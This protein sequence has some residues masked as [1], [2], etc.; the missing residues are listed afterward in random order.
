MNI[1][2]GI[3]IGW[4]AD[5]WSAMIV[6][7]VLWGFGFCVWQRLAAA[8]G[9][10]QAPSY[11]AGARASA[12]KG[13]VTER[14]DHLLRPSLFFCRCHRCDFWGRNQYA[15]LGTVSVI[16]TRV[17]GHFACGVPVFEVTMVQPDVV[18]Q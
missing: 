9:I 3:V 16:G 6:A 5:T 13:H 7:A 8:L 11:L 1:L 15:S 14:G 18:H 10:G 2:A 4:F 12:A 17:N